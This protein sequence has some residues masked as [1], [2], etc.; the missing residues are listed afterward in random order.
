ML[1]LLAYDVVFMDIGGNIL[2]L[3]LK[4]LETRVLYVP[5]IGNFRL[6]ML[7]E[8]LKFVFKSV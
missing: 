6:L 4:S 1:Q 2:Q 7:E 3:L 5:V 8:S